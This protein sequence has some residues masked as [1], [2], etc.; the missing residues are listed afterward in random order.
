MNKTYFI[1]V[2]CFLSILGSAQ[3]VGI[4]TTSPQYKLDIAGRMRIKLTQAE[5]PGLRLDGPSQTTRSL[6]GPLDDDHIGI[7]GYGGA[8][9][10]FAMNVANGNI[11]M[12]TTTPAFKLDL[13]GRMRIQQDTSTAGIWFDGSSIPTRSMFGTFNDNYVGFMGNGGAGWNFVMNVNNGNIGIGTSS[14]TSKLDINGSIRIRSNSPVKGSVLTSV[15]A[16]GNAVWHNPE[17]FKAGGTIDGVPFTID[18]VTWTKVLFN[19]TVVHNVGN[20]Y[21]PSA[22]EYSVLVKG[23][24]HF[25]AA[26]AFLERADKQ[27]IRVRLKRNGVTTT[28]GEVYHQGFIYHTGFTGAGTGPANFD[29]PS[30]ISVQADL[31][32]GDRVWVEAYIDIYNNGGTTTSIDQG[33][34]RTWF[35]GKLIARN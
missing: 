19:Q 28:I 21:L 15:D 29:E 35:S 23:L 14:P 12:G 16:D 26:I 7:Y 6:L 9:Y 31:L 17:A 33:L 5:Y 20:G 32:P 13:K 18:N 24:Y 8:G 10:A 2:L 1:V 11:G 25:K 4:G 34:D 27:S 22:S 30:Q 3:N